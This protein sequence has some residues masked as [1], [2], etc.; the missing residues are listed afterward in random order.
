MLLPLL[1]MGALLPGIGGAIGV[2][3]WGKY[4]LSTLNLYEWEGVNHVPP[5]FWYVRCSTLMLFLLT[6][7]A[8]FYQIGFPFTHGGG[9][10]NAVSFTSQPHICTPTSAK[11]L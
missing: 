3:Q 11:C 6:I 7:P 1:L 4:W 10:F 9:G 5:E 8:G 2:P